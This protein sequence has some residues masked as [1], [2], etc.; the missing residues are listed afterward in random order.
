M[1]KG[2]PPSNFLR[3]VRAWS[4]ESSFC[5][6]LDFAKALLWCWQY[7]L[8]LHWAFW[9]FITLG[10]ADSRTPPSSKKSIVWMLTLPNMAE[11][12]TNSIST[13]WAQKVNADVDVI[14]VSLWRHQFYVA[15]GKKIPLGYESIFWELKIIQG[16]ITT[17][18]V[19][20]DQQFIVTLFTISYISPFS[21]YFRSK[22]G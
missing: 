6:F 12:L 11:V 16:W 9:C 8:Y 3:L 22:W 14:N 19:A 21:I 1:Y 2:P 18:F 4:E 20:K 10:G 5:I 17:H 7:Q 13:F 15:R